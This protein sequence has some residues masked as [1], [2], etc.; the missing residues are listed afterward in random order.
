MYRSEVDKS[1]RRYAHPGKISSPRNG[2]SD[3]DS[4]SGGELGSVTPGGGTKPCGKNGMVWNIWA[5]SRGW[6]ALFGDGAWF[7][8]VGEG[9]GDADVERVVEEPSRGPDVDPA[10]SVERFCREKEFYSEAR[11]REGISRP[12][13]VYACRSTVL[14][15]Q[16]GVA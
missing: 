1:F 7:N 4:R 12:R 5:L 11:E 14:L 6:S 8:S 9:E 3:F 10:T 16:F 2:S 15:L 13:Q